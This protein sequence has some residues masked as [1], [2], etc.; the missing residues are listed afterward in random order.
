MIYVHSDGNWKPRRCS[1]SKAALCWSWA[2]ALVDVNVDSNDD[3]G[4]ADADAACVL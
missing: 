3:E 2:G 4:D 1:I